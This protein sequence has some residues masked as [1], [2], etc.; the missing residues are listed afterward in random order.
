M[1][2]FRSI[3]TR[4]IV[5]LARDF[6]Y[7]DTNSHIVA[8]PKS[9]GIPVDF[10]G[11]LRPRAGTDRSMAAKDDGGAVNDQ[12]INDLEM[13]TTSFL[14]PNPPS[15]GEERDSDLRTMGVSS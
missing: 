9:G 12:E 15:A 1:F 10:L 7:R 2:P 3:K 6:S 5:T 4:I 14:S 11:G 8:V 13:K